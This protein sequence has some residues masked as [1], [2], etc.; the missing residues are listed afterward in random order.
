MQGTYLTP[1]KLIK[2][3]DARV[4]L[5]DSRFKLSLS[6][7]IKQKHKISITCTFFRVAYCKE[8]DAC[9]QCGILRRHHLGTFE[10]K[11]YIRSHYL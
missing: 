9:S 10:N 3:F 6:F 2:A 7:V 8:L 4:D 11:Q 5:T 1:P